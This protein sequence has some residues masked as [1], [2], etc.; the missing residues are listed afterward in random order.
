MWAAAAVAGSFAL[1][2]ALGYWLKTNG[3][4]EGDDTTNE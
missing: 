3:G 4:V 1:A 2:L